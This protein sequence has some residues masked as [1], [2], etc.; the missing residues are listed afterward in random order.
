MVHRLFPGDKNY[1]L[2]TVQESQR[3]ML[4]CWMVDSVCDYYETI[5]NPLG[6]EDDTIIK[7]RNNNS[8]PLHFFKDFYRDL[9]GIYR[10]LNNDNQLELL[11]DGL[12]H[13]EH[14]LRD[15]DI[16]FKAW[17]EEFMQKKHFIQTVITLSVF[18]NSLGV[19]SELVSNR[20][21]DLLEKHFK[22]KFYKFKGI[23]VRNSA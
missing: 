6:L 7:I 22:L 23:Q 5:Y 18:T 19:S 12:S 2:R 8:Y 1:I 17:I 20:F 10:Y 13:E 14:F 21:R 15:W 3:D 16:Q 9:A 11:F 4:L